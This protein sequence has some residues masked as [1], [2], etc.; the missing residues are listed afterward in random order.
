MISALGY[1]AEVEVRIGQVHGVESSLHT[2]TAAQ[3][4]LQ[5][6]KKK[7]RRKG[8]KKR[9]KER[10]EEEKMVYLGNFNQFGTMT[11]QAEV[12]RYA[13]SNNL[14]VKFYD[15]TNLV[16]AKGGKADYDKRLKVQPK[17]GQEFKSTDIPFYGNLSRH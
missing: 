13:G 7:E 14:L 16:P 10:E 4:K 5:S 17:I 1:E 9:E 15:E 3:A 8:R 2:G 6:G 12:E 11:Y